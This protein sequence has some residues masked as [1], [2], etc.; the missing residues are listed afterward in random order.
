MLLKTIKLIACNVDGVLLMDTFSPVAHDLILKAGIEYTRE[1]ERHTFSQNRK[2]SR[3]YMM[4]TY[5]MTND[6]FEKGNAI[7]WKEREKYI[8]THDCGVIEGVLQFLELISTLDVHLVC[9]GGLS[10]EKKLEEF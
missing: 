8:K 1:L 7:Y 6:E 9:Y 5:N 3:E 2:E 4:K 10:E